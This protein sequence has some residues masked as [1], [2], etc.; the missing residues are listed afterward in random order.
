MSRGIVGMNGRSPEGE[1]PSPCRAETGM[2][3]PPASLVPNRSRFV[4]RFPF[5]GTRR[6]IRNVMEF[7]G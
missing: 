1:N 3:H 7:F 2:I 6:S 5:V 4:T